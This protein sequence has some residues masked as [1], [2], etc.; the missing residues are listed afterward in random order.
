MKYY[1]LK[2]K[3]RHD[4]LTYWYAKTRAR[5][6]SYFPSKHRDHYK[7][8]Y[9]NIFE[10]DYSFH[11]FNNGVPEGH[12]LKLEQIV[13][14]DLV[15]REDIGKLQKGIR[16]LLKQHRSGDRFIGLPVDGLDEICKRIDRMDAVLL[17][18]YDSCKCGI[19]DFRG[20]SLESSID[21]FTLQVKNINSSYLSVEF[22][23][24]LTKAK[25]DELQTIIN[26]DYHDHRGYAHKTLSSRKN[27]G[28]YSSYTVVHYND[29]F[30]KADYISK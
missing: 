8:N 13:T 18:G 10:N 5:V 14:S 24:F 22:R 2:M 1:G 6:K 17:S 30:L 12:W 25:M 3:K 11:K 23:V 19:F 7:T 27:G 21:Y 26:K 16:N 29:E 4:D 28:A 15:Y 20:E 9:Q